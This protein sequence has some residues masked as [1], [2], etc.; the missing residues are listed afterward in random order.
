MD[1]MKKRGVDEQGFVLNVCHPERIQTEF[2]VVVDQAVAQL[3][4]TFRT[5]IHSIYLYGSVARG[6]AKRCHSDLDM[7][8]VFCAPLTE[9]DHKRLKQLF[10]ALTEGFPLITKVDFDPGHLA[11]VL[12]PQEKFRWQFWLKHCCCCLW[13]KDL[14]LGFEA[15]RPN[16]AIAC[17]LNEDLPEMVVML[18]S[19]LNEDNASTRGRVLAK[20]LLRSACGLLV[21]QHRSWLVEPEECAGVIRRYQPHYEPGVEMALMILRKGTATV[22]EVVQLSA[23]FAQPLIEEYRRITDNHL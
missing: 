6:E 7:S 15:C 19:G 9:Q 12:H 11:E 20:K 13:G 4:S 23:S 5:A 14:A 17:A 18:N 21:E 16:L 1:N 2:R 22:N 10:L 3:L 8:V